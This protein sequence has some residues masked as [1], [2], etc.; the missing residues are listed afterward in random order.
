MKDKNL[1]VLF[2]H[3]NRKRGDLVNVWVRAR[4][5]APV[6]SRVVKNKRINVCG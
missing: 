6:H 3:K 4:Y 1:P 5:S 2:L